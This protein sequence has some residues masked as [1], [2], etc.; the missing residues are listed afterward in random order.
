MTDILTIL[1]KIRTISKYFHP[2]ILMSSK[3]LEKHQ[4]NKNKSATRG[5]QLLLI[6]LK[7]ICLYST[8]PNQIS[9]WAIARDFDNFIAYAQMLTEPNIDL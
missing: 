3:R 7:S 1:F 5:A 8:E 9:M 4:Q 2:A 6:G